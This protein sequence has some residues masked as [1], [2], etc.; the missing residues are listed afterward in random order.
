MA[1][2]VA[3][4]TFGVTSTRVIYRVNQNK[5]MEYRHGEKLVKS[6]N[7]GFC[8]LDGYLEALKRKCIESD[9]IVPRTN[10][11]APRLVA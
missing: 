1:T 2:Q 6:E 9:I 10:T 4:L 5:P 8:S 7:S 11:G 3:F